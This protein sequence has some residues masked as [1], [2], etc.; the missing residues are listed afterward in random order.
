MICIK[1]K[2]MSI[3]RVHSNNKNKIF[4]EISL[5]FNKLKRLC[6]HIGKPYLKKY[7]LYETFNLIQKQFVKVTN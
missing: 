7:I 6:I 4:R 1:I 5:S 3:I 2:C